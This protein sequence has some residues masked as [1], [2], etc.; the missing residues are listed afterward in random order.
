[1]YKACVKLYVL[2]HSEIKI[3]PKKYETIKKNPSYISSVSGITNYSTG[4]SKKG[5]P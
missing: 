5:C 2:I 4:P 3:N 1:M